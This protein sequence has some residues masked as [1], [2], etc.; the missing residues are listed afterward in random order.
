M[1]TIFRDNYTPNLS[2]YHEKIVVDEAQGKQWLFDCDGVFTDITGGAVDIT[3]EKG[4][5]TTLAVS[6]KLFTDE[7]NELEEDIAT[8]GENASQALSEASEALSTASDVSTAVSN[9]TTALESEAEAR[10]NADAALGNR[11]TAIENKIPA[12]ASSSNQ[13]ADKDFVNSSVATNTANFKG[14]FNTIEELEAVQNPT[15]NDYG[16]VISTDQQG[17]TVY[18]R[19]KYNGTA[20]VFEYALNNSSFTASQWASINSGVT[21][22]DVSKLAGIETGAEAN[23]NADWNA[24]SGDAQILNKPDLSVYATNSALTTGL[25]TKQDTISDLATIRSGAAA[26]ATAVQPGDLATVATSGSYNDLSNKPTIPTVNNSTITITNNG[27]TVDS[28]T[29]NA[30]SAKTIALTSP[31]ITMT[32]TD[33]GEGASLAANHFIAVYS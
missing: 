17:N 5:S 27:T 19:Y 21:T 22:A 9:L 2:D 20:W 7:I 26:G 14:T 23:V 6:Q 3:Q 15:N 31:V 32:T 11:V 12:Q 4:Q 24:T 8:A 10:S 13:L 16:F 18:N 30:S 28:F 25:A 29:T 33:P 1:R